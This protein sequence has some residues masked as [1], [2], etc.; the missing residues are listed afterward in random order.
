MFGALSLFLVAA[1]LYGT[2]AF[3]VARRTK[4]L[5]LRA[6]L[7]AGRMAILALVLKQGLGV[8]MLG[9]LV[10]IVASS[11]GTRFLEGL[12]FGTTPIDPA[13]LVWVSLVL[14]LVAFAAAY[15][16]ARRALRIDPMSALRTE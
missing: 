1:G 11:W 9:I 2:I 7:G 4:E 5:G 12:L 6:S 10:G 16:P 8:T 3:A 13:S 14:F 15:V